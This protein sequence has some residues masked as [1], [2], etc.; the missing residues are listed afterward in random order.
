MINNV[1]FAGREECL[2]RMIKQAPAEPY[3]SP[4]SPVGNGTGQAVKSFVEKMPEKLYL[5]SSLVEN[6]P[7]KKISGNEIAEAYRAAH[8]ILG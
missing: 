8:G 1:T 5:D 4:F 7:E 3:F 2:T 6:V